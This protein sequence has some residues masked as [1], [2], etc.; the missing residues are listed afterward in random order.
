MQTTLCVVVFLTAWQQPARFPWKME[1]KATATYDATLNWTLKNPGFE[2]VEWIAIS[3]NPPN[4][5]G[6]KIHS[7]K[8]SPGISEEIAEDSPLQRAFLRNR[9]PAKK[10]DKEPYLDS[11]S[12]VLSIQASL[13]SRKVVPAPPRGAPTALAPE[14]LP[15]QERKKYLRS[16]ATVDF[17]SEEFRRWMKEE[18]LQRKSGEDD[19]ALARRYFFL[20]RARYDFRP[21]AKGLRKASAT[22]VKSEGDFSGI[23]A[24]FVALCRSQGIPAR[25]LVGRL[26]KSTQLVTPRGGGA[27]LSNHQ[28]CIRAEWWHPDLAWVPV[29]LMSNLGQDRK[30]NQAVKWFGADP[31]DMI[32]FHVD[33]DVTLDPV[34]F[35]KKEL[36]GTEGIAVWSMGKGKL[37]AQTLTENW[38][39]KK[40]PRP[41]EKPA[42][43]PDSKK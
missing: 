14:P 16:S 34:V 1:Q 27:A 28:W 24:L 10:E 36:V 21:D 25:T 2:A 17:D 19:W 38:T 32:V 5:P 11:L 33:F 23:H 42:P 7:V 12:A 4:L 29:D 43:K 15:V 13:T 41:K 40:I 18:K 20:I 22:A 35:E 39:V 3:A 30:E 31:G 26:A 9:I 37:D 6:Q 8:L